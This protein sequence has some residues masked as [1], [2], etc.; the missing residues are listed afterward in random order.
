MDLDLILDIIFGVSLI[1]FIISTALIMNKRD[2]E[3]DAQWNRGIEPCPL[4]KWE[5]D[6]FGLYCIKCKQRPEQ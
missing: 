6:S 2:S 4:H 1:I 3:R 5:K